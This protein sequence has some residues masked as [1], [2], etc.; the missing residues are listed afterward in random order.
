MTAE[1]VQA[2]SIPEDMSLVVN[3]DKG[4]VVLTGCG[5]AGVVNVVEYARHIV[6]SQPAYAVVG[7]LHLFAASDET[8]A[9][10]AARLRASG[11][12]A[13]LGAHC[14]GIEAVFRIRQLAGLSRRTA[15]VAAVGSSFDLARGIDPLDLAQ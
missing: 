14:T 5:H 2:D 1:G 15:V 8:L 11:L 9:W 13:L 12:A 3:T 10:T 6:P 7:G 4:L